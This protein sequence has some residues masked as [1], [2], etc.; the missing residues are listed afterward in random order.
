MLLLVQVAGYDCFSVASSQ[1]VSKSKLLVVAEI[2]EGK[3]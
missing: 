2:Q 1:V 3:C